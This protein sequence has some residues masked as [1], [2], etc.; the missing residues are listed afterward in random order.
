MKIIRTVALKMAILIVIMVATIGSWEVI[1]AKVKLVPQASAQTSGPTI[2]K[3]DHLTCYM[4]VRKDNKPLEAAHGLV[5]DNQ[6]GS[7]DV[8]TSTSRYLCVPT[9][10]VSLDGQPVPPPGPDATLPHFKCY[11][12]VT[13]KGPNVRLTD[14]FMSQE[15]S[16]LGGTLGGLFCNPVEKEVLP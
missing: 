2:G 11:F 15:Y 4:I 13:P 8:R 12:A 10:K 14:E 1:K 9:T 7:Q 16:V 5:V 6:F 3:G